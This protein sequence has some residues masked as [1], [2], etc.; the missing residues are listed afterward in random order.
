[1]KMRL[2]HWDTRSSMPEVRQ[3]M[4]ED[5]PTFGAVAVK[6]PE[7]S[8]LGQWGVMTLNSGGSFVR[9]TQVADWTV[10]TP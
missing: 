1:M 8:P 5:S 2:P 10:L 7:G 9:D 3:D 6:F 4:R